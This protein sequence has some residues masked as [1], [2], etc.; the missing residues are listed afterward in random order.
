MA[1]CGSKKYDEGGK[2]K[3]TD[4]TRGLEKKIE[5]NIKK[6]GNKKLYPSEAYMKELREKDPEKHM[7]M[8]KKYFTGMKAGGAVKMNKGGMLKKPDNP[9]LKKLPTEVRNKMGYMKK[10]GAVKKCKRD[11]VC[12]K[13]KTKG[14]MV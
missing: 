8:V 7:K 3:V 11:G 5:K 12:V 4:D 14:R 10:G 13:G 6:R 9:G 2:I 1:G